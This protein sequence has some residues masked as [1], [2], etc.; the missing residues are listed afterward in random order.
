MSVGIKNMGISL[1]LYQFITENANDLIGIITK[2]T[3]YEYINKEACKKFLGYEYHE[4]VS[5]RAIDFIHHDDLP[6][7]FKTIVEGKKDG[8]AEVIIRFKHKNG[9][10]LWLE[11][12]GK[13]FIDQDGAPKGLLIARDVTDR[14][15]AEQKLKESE[16]KFRHLF[17][18]SPY[19]ILLFDFKGNIIDC[20][21]TTEKLFG[22]NKRELLHKN[23]L[24]LNVFPPEILPLLKSR[25][26]LLSNGTIPKPLEF[27]MYKKNGNLIW[28]NAT[29]SLIEIDG[30]KRIQVI[31]QDI[32]EKK[33]GELKLRES[34]ERYRLIIENSGAVVWT[35]DMNL[36]LT[37]VSPSSPKILGYTFEESMSL[38]INSIVTPESIKI[39]AK[40]LREELK[41][42]KKKDKDLERSRTFE[43]KQIH[44]NGTIV[45]VE[46]TIT[47]LRDNKGEAI[48]IL[49]ISRDIT[50]RK[51]MEQ[52]LKESENRYRE[53]YNRVN[54]YKDLFTH[55]IINIF[56]AIS[57]STEL[58]KILNKNIKFPKESEELLHIIKDQ[59]IRGRN[60]IS[61]VRKLSII[62]KSKITLKSTGIYAIF[63]K[64]IKFVKDSF[65]NKEIRI[66]YN[67]INKEI[68]VYANELLGDVFENI[69]IN[70]VKYNSNEIIEIEIRVSRILE[71][72]KQYIKME[73]MDNGIGIQDARKEII[74]QRGVL[75]KK[76][77]KG[78]GLGLS[79]V[80]KIIEEYGGKI[81]VEDRIKGEYSRGSNFILLLPEIPLA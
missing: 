51:R 75:L 65:P 60:L 36:N 4:L 9:N 31:V 11:V 55:D 41:I 34:E 2:T 23:Y 43:T 27:Q 49:G 3:K 73:F 53:A 25:Q 19:S 52:K 79:L 18:S 56:Q 5:K 45:P 8:E 44:K 69:L 61:N 13:R 42:E 21:S 14:K 47:F 6:L 29:N 74:F 48:G 78:M 50:E 20:N 39:M 64:C 76:D 30:Q 77:G 35:T 72:E 10:W 62:E 1:E 38:P 80:A 46:L 67:Y 63:E 81:W 7:V 58:F 68:Y 24:E 71:N 66:Q 40:I 54:F 16:E 32:S 12:R 33:E 28:V 26:Q 15:L 57:S 22:Y 59:I 37:Y 17:E 70:A